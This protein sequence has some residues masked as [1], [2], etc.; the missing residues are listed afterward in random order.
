MMDDERDRLDGWK[1]MMAP[2]D[3]STELLSRNGE[4][5]KA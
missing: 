5:E 1:E 2:T 3:N 4:A